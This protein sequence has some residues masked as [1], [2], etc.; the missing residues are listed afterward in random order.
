MKKV[1][2]F[3]L[4]LPESVTVT[5]REGVMFVTISVLLGIIFGMLCSP[6]KNIR[7]GCNNGNTINEN[8]EDE[9]FSDE[10][11]KM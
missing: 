1:R 6:R 2:E 7:F 3:W 9:V 10:E 11:E 5:R 8:W 4:K